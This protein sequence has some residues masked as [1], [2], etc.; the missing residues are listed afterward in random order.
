MELTAFV[1]KG[2]FWFI[3]F[4]K[5]DS[6][7]QKTPEQEFITP[8]S[9]GNW[10]YGPLIMKAGVSSDCP[11]TQGYIPEKK[12]KFLTFYNVHIRTAEC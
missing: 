8:R 1:F 4:R 2:Q 6:W 9:P 12:N 10:T 7:K 3:K 5:H 11:V